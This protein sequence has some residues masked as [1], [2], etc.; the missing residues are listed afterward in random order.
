MAEVKKKKSIL[1]EGPITPAKMADLMEKHQ[2]KTHCG[3][4]TVFMGQVRADEID[5]K[6]VA[7]IDYSC[8]PE[9]VDKEIYEIREEAFGKYDLSCMHI[10]HSVGKVPVGEVSLLVMVSSAHRGPTFPS[11][12]E[13][14]NNIKERV[15][16]WKKEIFEDGTENWKEG[17]GMGK[18]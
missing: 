3:A 16:I 12:E 14:V 6:T 10:Y 1:I 2:N 15:P 18:A 17:E 7:A 8:Y 9:M 11:L 4:H 13:L 5:G